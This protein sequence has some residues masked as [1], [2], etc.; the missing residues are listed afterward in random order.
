MVFL[1]AE[2]KEPQKTVNLLLNMWRLLLNIVAN[3]AQIQHKLDHII[4][5]IEPQPAVKILFTANLEGKITE[6][7]TQ[8]NMT[9]SQ[10]VSLTIKPVDKK[11]NAAP[12]DGVPAWA[13]SNT[14]VVT[15]TPAPD[16]MSAIAAA[17][18]PLGS[19]TVSVTADADLGAGVTEIAGSLDIII[20]AG[21][22][23]TVSITAG[24]PEEQPAA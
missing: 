16:G 13:S 12:V 11:G 7:V 2:R 8:M 23:A 15:V 6:G 19:A 3:L 17:V 1:E 22:A 10:Q 14:E 18:G 4:D 5:L 21:A 9:D 20:T 24:S